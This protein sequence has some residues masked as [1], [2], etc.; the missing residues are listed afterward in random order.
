MLPRNDICVPWFACYV[1]FRH[2]KYIASILTHK[3]HECFVPT[4]SKTSRKHKCELPIFPG[5]VFSRVDPTTTID[6]VSTPG[7]FFIVGNGKSPEPIPE[8]EIEAIRR[9]IA[10]GLG[11]R[12]WRYLAP[13]EPIYIAEGPLSGMSGTVVASSSERW[14]VVSVHLLRRSVAVKLDRATLSL[15]AICANTWPAR[16][17]PL[18]PV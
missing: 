12:P 9:M 15:S 4:Y 6:V 14:L 5:Y 17:V 8:G 7:V 16:G 2:E 13:G 1:R 18:P 10:A 3:G 11:P